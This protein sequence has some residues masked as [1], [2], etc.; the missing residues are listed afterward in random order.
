[1]GINSPALRAPKASKGERREA[2]IQWIQPPKAVSDRSFR[3]TT[4]GAHGSRRPR[5]LL[6]RKSFGA[7]QARPLCRQGLTPPTA[8]RMVGLQP[9]EEIPP[10]GAR[11]GFKERRKRVSSGY[12]NREGPAA[13]SS[14]KRQAGRTA[15][16][17]APIVARESAG[18]PA[19]A[20]LCRRGLTRRLRRGW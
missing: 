13:R 3:Q 5:R 2:G 7:P 4:S 16:R 8:A 1:M 10:A 11:R 19:G 12:H 17:T 15:V 6:P 14:G 18:A 9:Q 20:Q